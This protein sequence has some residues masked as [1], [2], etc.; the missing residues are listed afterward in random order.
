LPLLSEYDQPIRLAPFF[1]VREVAVYSTDLIPG[2]V[3]VGDE[4]RLFLPDRAV[5]AAVSDCRGL[6]VLPSYPVTCTTAQ[7]PSEARMTG[8]ARVVVNL[9]ARRSASGV[10]P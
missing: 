8:H 2:V 3:V 9:C 5:A 10:P 6:S 4:D 7:P 1:T